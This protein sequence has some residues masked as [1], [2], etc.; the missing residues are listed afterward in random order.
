MNLEGC[1]CDNLTLVKT[2]TCSNQEC[3]YEWTT[4]M[5]EC[6]R[7]VNCPKHKHG[8]IYYDEPSHLLCKKCISGG[9]YFKFV[10]IKDGV[11]IYKC[12][13]NQVSEM[14]CEMEKDES[15]CLFGF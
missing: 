5:N 14:E 8:F 15:C 1:L 6:D 11:P 3:N 9:Y 12:E 10:E 13:K 4:R 2:V 7:I